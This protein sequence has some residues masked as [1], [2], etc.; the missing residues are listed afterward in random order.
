M[1]EGTV[2]EI[3]NVWDFAKVP[4]ERLDLCLKEFGVAVRMARASIELLDAVA[5]E[6]GVATDVRPLF[7]LT[8]TFEW[9][10]DDKG[11]A[12][13]RIHGHEEAMEITKQPPRPDTGRT[14]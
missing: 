1:A 10:D 11:I 5:D 8:E 9:I 7:G 13:M 12:T 14:E 2:Y 3:R 4:D 6:M